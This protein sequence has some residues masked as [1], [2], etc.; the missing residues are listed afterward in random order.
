LGVKRVVGGTELCHEIEEFVGFMMLELR[1]L[2]ARRS[3]KFPTI[4]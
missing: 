4:N 3:F 1:E 2:V